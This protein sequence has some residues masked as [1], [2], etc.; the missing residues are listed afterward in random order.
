[1]PY[2]RLWIIIHISWLFYGS[3]VKRIQL[4]IMSR[5]PMRLPHKSTNWR[6]FFAVVPCIICCFEVL[7][8]LGRQEWRF[9]SVLEDVLF[10]VPVAHQGTIQIWILIG[11]ASPSVLKELGHGIPI[12]PHFTMTICINKTAMVGFGGNKQGFVSGERLSSWDNGKSPFQRRWCNYKILCL[13]NMQDTVQP[14]LG[15]SPHPTFHSRLPSSVSD[16]DFKQVWPRCS[17]L[18]LN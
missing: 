1:M 5:E 13:W 11:G 3:S 2:L 14:L 8:K 9:C 16:C 4:R 6:T 18:S 7:F 10:L 12:C 17:K 15:F